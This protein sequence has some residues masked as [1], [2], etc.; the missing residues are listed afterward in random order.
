MRVERA[1]FDRLQTRTPAQRIDGMTAGGEQMAAPAFTR[2]HPLPSAVPIR[3]VRQVLRPRKSYG[4]QP[5]L[6]S[7]PARELQKRVVP[8]YERHDRPDTRSPDGVPH[9]NQFLDVERRRFLQD[10]ML[11]C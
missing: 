9:A 8:K 10:E 11:A 5:A 1:D 2:A 7:Q 4:A 6:A 3:N